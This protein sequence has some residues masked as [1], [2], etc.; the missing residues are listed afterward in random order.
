[1][2]QPI[3]ITFSGIDSAGKSTYID[4][5][6]KDF[7]NKNIKYK[8]VWSRGG[9]T[10]IFEFI[11]KTIRILAG[12]KLPKSGHSEQRDRMFRKNS[13]SKVWYT[14]AILDLI[15]LYA[16]TFRIYKL[17]GYVVI[18]D[19]YIWDTYVDFYFQ[20]SEGKLKNSLLWRILGFTH[21]KP[22]ISFFFYISPEESLRRSIEKEELFAE[23]LEKREERMK[24]YTRLNNSGKWKKSLNTEEKSINETWDVVRRHIEDGLL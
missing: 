11:K 4:L 1:M 22:D 23:S 16:I 3:M 18:C 9:Y 20:F 13:V 19:R 2:K 12:K 15:R 14:I 5:L 17:F 24:V 10:S 7:S 21:R 8:V 6:K